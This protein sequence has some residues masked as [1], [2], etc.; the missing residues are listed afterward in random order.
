MIWP[1]APCAGVLRLAVRCRQIC[2][3]LE[4]REEE[5][6]H[7]W[8]HH[9]T[10]PA[11]DTWKAATTAFCLSRYWCIELAGPGLFII[12]NLFNS[13]INV[14][15]FRDFVSDATE[16]DIHDHHCCLPT[17]SGG[18]RSPGSRA[19][20][21]GCLSRR[22]ASCSAAPSTCRGGPASSPSRRSSAPASVRVI[23]SAAVVQSRR[24]PLLG[25]S[26]GW[27]CLLPYYCF[28]I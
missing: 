14:R 1:S 8:S 17:V 22:G 7:N 6:S 5:H 15:D 4:F 3:Q 20:A 12:H 25:P 27:K 24:R 10:A 26:P 11:T 23:S 9:C 21:W 18:V 16:A 19:G 13:D 28:D 2:R